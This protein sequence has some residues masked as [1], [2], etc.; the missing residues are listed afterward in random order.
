MASIFETQMINDGWP[1]VAGHLERTV[2]YTPVGEAGVSRVGIFQELEGLI[3]EEE[4]GIVLARQAHLKL[5]DT[6]EGI[7]LSPQ[8]GDTATTNGEVWQYSGH[9]TNNGIHTIMLNLAVVS[10]YDSG[11]NFEP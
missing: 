9:V 1:Q 8:S 7:S 11:A 5:N 10:E 6:L 2:T 4:P 3:N